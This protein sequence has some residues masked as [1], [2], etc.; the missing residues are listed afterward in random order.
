MHPYEFTLNCTSLHSYNKE[1]YGVLFI[2]PPSVELSE[3]VVP[4]MCARCKQFSRRFWRFRSI[5][6]SKNY[7]YVFFSD[8]SIRDG[9]SSGIQKYLI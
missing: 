1:N 4:I 8:V 2:I 5:F 7:S 9:S 6:G 3:N